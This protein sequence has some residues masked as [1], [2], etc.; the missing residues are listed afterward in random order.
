[1]LTRDQE[2][3]GPFRGGGTSG[4]GERGHI[5]C[6]RDPRRGT[7]GAEGAAEVAEAG[8]H[9]RGCGGTS[10]LVRSVCTVM[11]GGDLDVAS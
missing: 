2:K 11:L 10:A 4:A 9:W 5:G 3:L 6:W 8:V 7:A 1:M